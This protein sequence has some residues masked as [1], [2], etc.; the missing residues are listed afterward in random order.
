M[1]GTTS[2]NGCLAG[3]GY[4][5]ELNV[6]G[7]Y[8][9]GVKGGFIAMTSGGTIN[10]SGGEWIANTD[11]TPKNDNSA[12]LVAQNDKN[13]YAGAGESVINVTGGSFKGGYNCY[14]YTT[15]RDAQ[16]NISGGSFNADP[17]DYVVDGYQVCECKNGEYVILT[18]DVTVVTTADELKAALKDGAVILINAD[19][20][21]ATVKLPASL[22]NVTIKATSGVVIKNST[23]MASDGNA[24]S[25]DG[26]TFDGLTFDNSRIS[27]TGWRTGGA[28]VKNLTVTNCV[29]KNLDDNT[30]SAPLHINMAATEPVENLTFT[31]NV[32]DGATGGSKSGVYAQVTGKT[33]FTGNVINNV[34]FRPYVIQI[35]V[36][37]GI[38]DEFIVTGNTF[39]GSAA[40]RAQ[41]LGNNGEG[42]DN[43]SLVVSGN[44]FK[45]ITSSQQ[46]CYWNFNAEK[47]TAD[48]SKNYYD[49]DITAN[50]SMI[51]YNKAASSV[52]DLVE[53]GV[54]PF[55]TELNADGT[56]NE[57]SL[58]TN[59]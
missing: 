58:V 21:D 41:G 46:I 35:T 26:L 5:S 44:I 18:N 14:S 38:D 25:Y 32:I 29:F 53:M 20:S 47:T 6:Y 40:G 34:S 10:V 8:G 30:N 37:D 23:I 16:I 2:Y 39:S 59:K 4:N 1:N 48:L 13:T 51:Y 56:I 52:E 9:K 27:I 50:P 33:V 42:T 49:I 43:V 45:D 11:G 24:I 28:S 55:Y 19:I 36:D 17:A 57:N 7:G 31:N 15:A 3:V 22:N 12:I 54:Y